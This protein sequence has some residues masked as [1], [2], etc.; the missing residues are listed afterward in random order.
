MKKT[1]DP[2][3]RLLAAKYVRRQA[4][5]LAG[6]LDGVCRADDIEFVHRARVASRRL[7]AATRMFAACFPAKS[8]RRWKKEIRRITTRLGDA[9]DRDVQIE[10]LAETLDDV[11][12]RVHRPGIARLL[13]KFE[14]QRERLQRGVID[15]VGRLKK[16]KVLDQMQSAAKKIIDNAETR[17]VDRQSPVAVE[18]TG[19][20]ILDNLEEMVAYRESLDDAGDKQNHHAMRVAAKQLRYTLEIS[21]PVYGSLLDEP[22]ATVRNLQSLLGEVHDCDVW[23]ENLDAF[24]ARQRRRITKY[25]GHDGPFSRLEPGIDHL[26]HER[27]HRREEVFG[28]LVD[29]WREL[30]RA[31]LWGRLT[32]IVEQDGREPDA[33][34]NGAGV[35]G[36]AS[37]PSTQDDC[38]PEPIEPAHAEVE[39]PAVC[40]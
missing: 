3:Y 34:E 35:A 37:M 12:D 6:Q 33:V 7:R 20:H 38:P 1:I 28:Q 32:G 8:L 40:P 29:Y 25:F 31:G 30:D 2:S 36:E 4:K 14:Q 15:A 39:L 9:R 5:E 23:I 13:V 27:Q 21:K 22:I 17:Q 11:V 26:R 16:S 18:Q 10:F 19:R 24:A